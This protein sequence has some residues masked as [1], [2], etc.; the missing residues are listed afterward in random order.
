MIQ[1]KYKRCPR[2]DKKAPIYQD[3][4]DNCG[5]IFSRLTKASN[6]AGKIAIRNKEYNKV[7]YDKVLP[8][9]VNKWKLFWT[10]LFFGW[11]GLHY[12]K[13]GRYKT[14]VFMAVSC[15]LILIAAILPLNWF[16]VQY[17]AMLMWA[18]VLPASLSVIIWGVSVFKIA[19]NSFKVPISIDEE[20]VK[21]SLDKDLVD[22]ILKTAKQPEENTLPLSKADNLQKNKEV[23][24]NNTVK[25]SEKDDKNASL[26]NN[27]TADEQNKKTN[28]KDK[29]MKKVKVVCASCGATVRVFEDEKICPKCDE[30]LNG[31]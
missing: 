27:N 12:A 25:I 1:K 24:K 10:A 4:C 16:N 7:V 29:K 26:P 11:F 5:L 21:Q 8:K 28:K 6:R 9:D 31:D 2:C 20:L 13:V 22:D 14:F 23:E 18:L 30:P 19:F 3:R 17:L 15:M